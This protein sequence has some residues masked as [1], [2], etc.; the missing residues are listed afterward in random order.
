MQVQQWTC[1]GGALLLA[2]AMMGCGGGEDTLAPDTVSGAT[3]STEGQTTVTQPGVSVPVSNDDTGG[4][5]TLGITAPA[6]APA[7]V[8]GDTTTPAPVQTGTNPQA[9]TPVPPEDTEVVVPPA[10][11]LTPPAAVPAPTYD[12]PAAPIFPTTTFGA[13]S[14]DGLITVDSGAGLVFKV[15]ETTGDI[16]SIRYNGGPEMQY[17]A[18]G[19]HISSGLKSSKTT[20]TYGVVKETVKVTISTPTLTHYMLVRANENTIYMGTYVTAEPGVGELRWITRL[21]PSTL[22][23]RPP[24]SDLTDTDRTIESEDVFGMPNGETRSKYFGNQRAIDLTL[25]GATG[26][27]V[28]VFMVYGNR[29]TSSGGPFY[30]D[31]Q[32]QTTE[33]YNYMNSGHN[34]TEAMRMGFH[35]P[36]AL[37]FTRGDTPVI[38]D[39]RWMEEHSL[40][41]WVSAAARGS[42]SGT[43]LSG[44]NP[45]YPYVV[46]FSNANAQ[47]WAKA[48]AGQGTFTSPGM[49]PGT[50]KMTVYKNEFEVHTESVDVVAGKNTVIGTRTI[51]TD[52][53]TVQ[54]LWRIGDWDGTP[55][56]FLN[57]PRLRTMHP[58]DVRQSAWARPAYVVGR[59]TPANDF[60]PYQFRGVNTTVTIK[61]TLTEDQVGAATL[62]TGLTVAQ[63]GGR[64]RVTV[65]GW[66][67]KRLPEA[68]TQ[69]KGRSITLGSYRGNN[70]MYTTS[71]P[72]GT[73]VAGENTITLDVLSGSEGDGWLAPAYA[74]DAIDL[75]KTQ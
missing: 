49:K 34:Q 38:P 15:N 55:N 2:T 23:T 29:E 59:S 53:S 20:V 65:N 1:F 30:N 44:M 14:A 31:I 67:P 71:I 60:S 66:T 63:G 5:S 37:M 42:V 26:N 52:P 74:Y 45:A 39:M 18:K 11:D 35:G 7:P 33:I 75:I 57:G 24:A 72:K 3:P 48:A 51:V 54:P 36:Y 28:G 70:A 69:P 56:E 9:S 17:W 47:Y 8:T 16:Q 40:L 4:T 22:T 21:N 32:N 13:N 46:G 19:S 62:R 6:V 64:P 61:F 41:G 73:L 50:Y 68:S 25:R 12:T 43:G 27:N 10:T 58:S